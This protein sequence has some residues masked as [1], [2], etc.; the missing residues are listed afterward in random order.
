M[1]YPDHPIVA[2][3]SL[4][5]NGNPVYIFTSAMPLPILTANN[6]SRCDRMFE[7]SSRATY[8]VGRLRQR[9]KI[10]LHFLQHKNH[11]IIGR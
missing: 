9:S 7:I 2:Q 11:K 1:L 5:L 10:L 3:L 4:I 8:V 6:M